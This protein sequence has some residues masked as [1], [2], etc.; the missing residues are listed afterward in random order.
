MTSE[1]LAK[2]IWFGS[3]RMYCLLL[4]L[5]AVYA[6]VTSVRR[7]LYRKEILKS[8]RCKVPVV[9][10]GNIMVGGNGKTP[11]VVAIVNYLR[12]QGLRVGVVSRGY[13]SHPPV[14]PFIVDAGT[15]T[16]FS[17]DEPKLIASH[18][19]VNVYIDPVRSRAAELASQTV[20]VIV[21]DDGLQHYALKRD[22]EIIVID[23][24]RRLGNGCLF[25][26][27]PLREGKWR[28]SGV[29]FVINNG[30]EL[31]NG[32]LSMNLR[33]TGLLPVADTPAG[34]P[35]TGTGVMALAG[36]GCPERF[37]DTVKSMGYSVVGTIK[38]PDHGTVSDEEIL[39]AERK[40]PLLMTEKDYVKYAGL[41]LKNS[42]YV[43][44]E[45]ELPE[46]FYTSL[47][48]KIRAAGTR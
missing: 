12:R 2:K 25:P 45:A 18:T 44:V 35:P 47:L 4:P 37:Y 34:A 5:S 13:H 7:W 31:R 10:V 19:G 23:G 24:K 20:D 11:V 14:Y 32:E 36:I 40:Y 8:F 41:P 48:Q 38:A 15:D 39:E 16:V 30:G 26:A 9:V 28:M 22:V 17:G 29:D 21:T 6:A 46:S 3:S 27:G 33:V 43:P 42:Y 1:D